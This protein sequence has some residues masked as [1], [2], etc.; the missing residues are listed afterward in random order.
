[1]KLSEKSRQKIE[2][3]FR[4]YLRDQNFRLP[5][6]RFYAGKFSRHFTRVLKVQGIT[7][8]RRVLILPEL[9]WKSE[10]NRHRLDEEIVVHEITH[11][12]QYRREGFGRFLWKYLRDYRKNLRKA[13]ER[14]FNTRLEAY[15]MIPFEIEARQTAA[16]FVAW[17]KNK[18]VK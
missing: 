7:F 1:M 3:F 4:E 14:N 16:D 9:V 8:G 13:G 18:Q 5:E 15:L 17:S 10:G 2:M 11:V 12:L 6:V